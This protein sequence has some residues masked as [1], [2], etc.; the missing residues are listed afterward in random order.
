MESPKNLRLLGV[1]LLLSLLLSTPSI[2]LIPRYI[3][4]L[5]AEVR[6]AA[7]LALEELRKD[8]LWLINVEM[9][10]VVRKEEGICFTWEHRYRAR[11]RIEEPEILTT[12]ID[13]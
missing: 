2:V 13:A 9:Q 6:S 7:P 10:S 8:G 5:N 12:C 3:P 11:G 1:L 4:F